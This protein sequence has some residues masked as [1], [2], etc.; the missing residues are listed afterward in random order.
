LRELR[1]PGAPGLRV[2]RAQGASGESS[3]K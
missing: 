2:R 1:L 3:A